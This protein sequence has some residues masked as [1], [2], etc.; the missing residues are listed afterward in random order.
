MDIRVVDLSATSGTSDLHRAGTLSK[1]AAFTCIL[2]AVVVQQ[3]ALIIAALLLALASLA[4]DSRLPLRVVLGLAAYPGIFAALFALAA[5]PGLLG[6]ALFVLKAMTAALAAV[7]LVFTT[8]YPQ[9]FA[10]VQ[11]LTPEIVGD[12]LLMTYRSLFLLAEKFD[13]LRMSVRLRS[14]LSTGHPVRAA[15]ATAGALG[16]LVLYALDLS[17]REYDVLRLRGYQGR[18][19]LTLA[20]SGNAGFDAALVAGAAIV[21][22]VATGFRI[23]GPALTPYSWL[24]AAAAMLTLLAVTIGRMIAR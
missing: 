5:A 15:Q 7:I 3:N 24:P 21:L 18:L 13:R 2:A 11:R 19:R 17:Q 4:I 16:G 1:L 10:V 9:I 14:G 12:S 6:G 22:A 8:P 23:A 20:R